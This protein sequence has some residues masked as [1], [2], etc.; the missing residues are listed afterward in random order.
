MSRALST[1]YINNRLARLAILS[2]PLSYCP[3]TI[4]LLLDLGSP[5]LLFLFVPYWSLGCGP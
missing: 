4:R 1:Y 5:V 3:N 2:I